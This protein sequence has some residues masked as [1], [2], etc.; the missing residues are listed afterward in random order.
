VA[1]VLRPEGTPSPNQYTK[2][3]VLV[4]SDAKARS[5]AKRIGAQLRH[6]P[7]VSAVFDQPPVGLNK[8]I[9]LLDQPID[10]RELLPRMRMRYLVMWK[11]WLAA[12]AWKRIAVIWTP[13]GPNVEF[14]RGLVEDWHTVR[15]GYSPS[16]NGYTL[17]GNPTGTDCTDWG[18]PLLP[19]VWSREQ[20]QKRREQL[21]QS[22][23]DR[24]FMVGRA[25]AASA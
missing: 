1:G 3:H 19:S 10:R 12:C 7:H 25:R 5:M 17:S 6:S 13:V 18:E 4:A 2:T 20:L 16:L 9:L 15:F 24:A 22:R 11:D 14:F 8:H 23:F 21:G